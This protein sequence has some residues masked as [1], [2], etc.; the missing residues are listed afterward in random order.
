LPQWFDDHLH[1]ATPMQW[2]PALLADART[3]MVGA[4]PPRALRRALDGCAAL[5]E[6]DDALD[7]LVHCGDLWAPLG[8]E[9]TAMARLRPGAVLID[10]AWV[11]VWAGA[12]KLQAWRRAPGHRAAAARLSA[13]IELGLHEPQQWVSAHRLALVI[14]LAVARG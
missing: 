2:L 7:V 11:E 3:R 4:R 8:L 9:R 10:L 13:V 14:T 1:C 5:G 6:H 12:W